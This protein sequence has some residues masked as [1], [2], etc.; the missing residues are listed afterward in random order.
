MS[1][2][3]AKP[4]AAAPQADASRVAAIRN[5][6]DL[7]DG[8]EIAAFGERARRE[9]TASVE[10]LLAEVRS[11][12]LS[13]AGDILRQASG[14]T[15]ALDPAALAP[16]G[17]FSTRAGRLRRFRERFESAAVVLDGLG[18]DLAE[19]AERLQRR[20]GALNSLHEQAKTFILELDAYLEAGRLRLRDARSAPGPVAVIDPVGVE[21]AD[22]EPPAEDAGAKPRLVRPHVLTPVEAVERLGERLAELEAVRL[23]AVTQLSLVRLIQ[24]VD[25]P[26]ADDLGAA[27]RA[28][29]RWRED[30]TERLGLTAA[31]RGR[32]IRPDAVGLA[33]ARAA[34]EAALK[35]A[36]AALAEARARRQQAED[37]M[38]AAAK[39]LRR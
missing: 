9:V 37:Q 29:G 25:A 27:V 3:E 22:A 39:R 26:L 13:E 2:L 1:V 19:R 35:G 32:K 11:G 30:W 7:R 8:A 12:D 24:N 6:L 5:S 20:T 18:G 10:R 21:T 33:E 38:E 4:A 34:L 23:V 36:D 28:L 16:R 31:L 14:T 15:Q 17:L